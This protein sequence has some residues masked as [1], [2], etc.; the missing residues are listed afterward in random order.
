[1]AGRL[2]EFALIRRH[3]APLSRGEPGARELRDDA[4]SLAVPP[5]HELVVTADAIVAGVHFPDDSPP[6]DV[7]RRILRV[8]LSDVAA[9]GAQA[10]AYTL[11]VQLPPAVDEDWIAGF[12][13]TLGE[14][15]ARFGVSLLGGDTTG[16][17]GPLTL[18][19]NMFGELPENTMIR[20]D[21]ARI[22]DDVYV[23]GTI[24]DAALGLRCLQGR[25]AVAA[26]A[27]RDFLTGRFTAPEPRVALG[28]ALRGVAHAAADV[29]DGL[30]A[31]LGHICEASG[32]GAEIG[33]DRVPIS[34]AARRAVT[35]DQ[36]LHVSLLGGGDDYEIVFAAPAGARDELDRIA[37]RT[38][39]SV[40]RIG[41][42]V[43]RADAERP[44]AVLD[45]AGGRIEAGHGGYR[46]FEQGTGG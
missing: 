19:L 7:A 6:A 5:G 18:S 28:P 32:V 45:G 27:D 39:T 16:T 9:K 14:E 29:S 2:D 44:V 46:H 30:V 42:I 12:A 26:Q 37:A 36:P 21:G 38:G 40:S 15:Q 23:S 13:Q 43:E 1:M 20:R 17:P 22:G 25:L 11:T 24:G 4:A 33:I 3:F 8:N 31:D 34:P 35:D 41:R 10:R